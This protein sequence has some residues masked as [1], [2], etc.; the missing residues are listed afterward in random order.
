M[1]GAVPDSTDTPLM[2]QYLELKAQV[3]DCILFFRLGDFYEMFFDDAVLVS[4]T[5]ELTLTSRDKGKENPIP[6]C[7]VPHHSAR[8][9]LARLVAAGHRVA[10]CEQTEDPKLAKG[11]VKREV[12]RIVTPGVQLDENELD[13]K[14]NC[15]LCAVVGDGARLGLAALDVST[16][17]FSVTETARDVLVDELARWQPREVLHEASFDVAPWQTRLHTVWTRLP[18]DIPRTA[19]TARKALEEA[20]GGRLA[21]GDELLGPLALRAGAA[22]VGYARRTQ[23]NGTLPITRMVPYRAADALVL[24]EATRTN[25]ELFATIS[26]NR[27]EGSL[28]GVLDHTRTAMGGR[29]LRRWL[30]AP[31]VDVAQIRRRQ[32]AVA[33]LVEHAAFRAELGSELAEIYDLP[34]LAARVSLGVASPKD[35]IALRRSLARLP[36]IAARVAAEYATPEAR[37]DHPELLDLGSDLCAEVGVAI[38]RVLVEDPPAQWRDGGFCKRGWSPELDE[39]LDLSE[40]GKDRVAQIETRE[41]ER[42]GIGSLKIR[43]NRV[44]GYYLEITRSNLDRVP[45][46]YIRKQTLANAE[47]FVTPE[48]ADYEAKI[49]HADERRVELE[50]TVWADLSTE[51]GAASTRLRELGDTVGRLD[52]LYSLAE[53]AHTQGYCRPLVDE[54][55]ILEIEDGRHPV[56]ERLAAEGR[57]VPN[58]LRLDPDDA[59]LIILTGPNMAGKSTAMRQAALITI[60]AQM[61]GFVPARAAT[62]GLCDRVFTRVGASDNLARGDSTFMVEMR[63]TAHILGHA[64]RRSLVVLDEIGRGTSTY[65]GMAIAWAVAEHL[66]DA[67]GCKTLFATHYHELTALARTRPRVRNFSTAVREW[68]DEVVFLHKIVAGGASRSYGIQV[69]RLAGLD[70]KVI[71][72]AKDL[73]ASL[74]RGADRTLPSGEQLSLLGAEPQAAAPQTSPTPASEIETTLAQ[75]DLDG[76]SPREAHTVL[77][78]LVQRA[79]RLRPTD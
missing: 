13:P 3:P 17:D 24:D 32:D 75:L 65:D 15:Y 9:H 35:L 21:L 70:K 16:G 26:G 18:E 79:R 4:R 20:L 11:I 2:R 61:G 8:V 58:D 57:F 37:I 12:V 53:V 60:M 31:L 51:V 78:E 39:L 46:D 19:P 14:T 73:L 28:L 76:I 71:G 5:L 30:A 44:F 48:L 66:H 68:R 43:Y 29:L 1:S 41:R 45:A 47:R 34:R 77:A 74:E 72:R 7:G 42:T 49:L 59:Q 10:I 22:A 54:G 36:A 38:E 33:W 55:V 63:E 67:I 27:K 69:A 23:P 25:L 40:S 62:V 6:M 52:A 56:V 50:L 64:T